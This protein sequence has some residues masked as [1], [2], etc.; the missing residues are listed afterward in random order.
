[1]PL[2]VACFNT[3][4]AL[5]AAAHGAHRIEL[6]ACPAV[7][8]TTP[9]LSDFHFVKSSLGPKA[10]GTEA[11]G[12]GGDSRVLGRIPVNVMIRPR[13]GDFVYSEDEFTSMQKD[14]RQFKSAGAD[15]FVFGILTRENEVDVERCRILLAEAGTRPCTFHR[16][17]DC[18]PEDR[19][20][21]Q[22]QVLVDLG[23]EYVLTS[24]GAPDAVCGK[25]VLKK[26][27][28]SAGDEIRVIVGGGVRSS[29]LRALRNFVDDG[30]DGETT[31]WWHSSAVTDG[32]EIASEEE[33]EALESVLKD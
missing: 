11:G 12:A 32:G 7:G 20:L 1:M 2:E 28:Q 5:H 16:A 18:I 22:L 27:I 33:I 25:E 19:M 17:F 10:P 31:G 15:G 21:E 30:K 13:G 9:P 26:L 4:S 6:C 3:A 29:N 23:F 8:G 14:I 24:G